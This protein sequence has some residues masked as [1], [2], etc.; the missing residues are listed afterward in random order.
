M[1]NP[2]ALHEHGAIARWTKHLR[3]ELLRAV[4]WGTARDQIFTGTGM[5]GWLVAGGPEM[6]MRPLLLR[7]GVF[8]AAH[9]ACLS[10]FLLSL[11]CSSRRLLSPAPARSLVFSGRYFV[12]NQDC[13]DIGM[14]QRAGD[15]LTGELTG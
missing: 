10:P 9:L 8:I 15:A 3:D 6:S 13:E 5:H 4:P 12:G 14:F 11:R 2:P 1:R 7:I